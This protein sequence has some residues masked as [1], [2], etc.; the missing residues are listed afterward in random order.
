MKIANIVQKVRESIVRVVSDH[1]SGTGVII[2]DRGIV[3]TNHHIINSDR[4]AILV[5]FDGKIHIGRMLYADS[6]RDIALLDLGP[7]RMLAAKLDY[8]KNVNIGEEI[9]TIGH[10][11]DL[12]YS[13]TK[14]IV[15]YPSR[16]RKEEPGLPY[17][18]FDAPTHPGS[19]GGAL[20]NMHGHVIGI[21][22]SGI[23]E[24]ESLNLA[25]PVSEIKNRIVDIKK[26]LNWFKA[27]KYCSICGEANEPHERHC[28]RCGAKLI[29]TNELER[30]I[31]RKSI[32]AEDF[33][34]CSNCKNPNILKDPE[35]KYCG[36][37]FSPLFSYLLKEKNERKKL[38]QKKIVCPI[39]KKRNIAGLQ[40]C[41]GCGK[42]L[43]SE[44]ED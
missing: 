21:V 25:I 6:Y 18:Q 15:S 30:I 24:S 35:N 20:L 1:G 9:I 38:G 7:K 28:G 29:N 3:L 13:I 11:K 23:R 39:C 14:G 5:S 40:Y 26:R 27:S 10:P 19:S 33:V 42:E 43:M 17:I 12:P 16:L 31:K 2:D 8:S 41:S 32:E 34:I 4:A 36:V 44:R 22:C 37:C